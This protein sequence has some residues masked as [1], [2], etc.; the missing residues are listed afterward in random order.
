MWQYKQWL[1]TN[2]IIKFSEDFNEYKTHDYA[3]GGWGFFAFE[4]SQAEITYKEAQDSADIQL[5]YDI[6]KGNNLI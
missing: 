5:T 4:L 3:D 6:L 1:N 2:K